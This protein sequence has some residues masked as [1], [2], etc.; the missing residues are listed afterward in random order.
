VPGSYSIIGEFVRLRVSRRG[1]GRARY[2]SHVDLA[3]PSIMT[4]YLFARLDRPGLF[5]SA[6]QFAGHT[7]ACASYI[8]TAPRQHKPPT[9]STQEYLLSPRRL[10]LYNPLL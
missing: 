8:R 4:R 9:I 3:W 10:P 2:H 7:S 6:F 1:P 5:F